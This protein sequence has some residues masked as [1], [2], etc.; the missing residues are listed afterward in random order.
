[1]SPGNTGFIADDRGFF[2]QENKNFS[3][4]IIRN[5]LLLLEHTVLLLEIG[6]NLH[7]ATV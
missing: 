2:E 6:T 4:C 3:I 7:N 1:M 5:L